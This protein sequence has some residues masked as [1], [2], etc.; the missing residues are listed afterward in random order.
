MAKTSVTS[1]THLARCKICLPAAWTGFPRVAAQ[2][3]TK[4][5]QQSL[6]EPPPQGVV[7]FRPAAGWRRQASAVSWKFRCQAFSVAVNQKDYIVLIGPWQT[8]L[9]A[10]P[11]R[12]S[13][14]GGAFAVFEC[15]SR[16]SN[17]SEGEA[18]LKIDAPVLRRLLFCSKPPRDPRGFIEARR[19]QTANRLTQVY[20]IEYIACVH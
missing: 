8:E 4:R 18:Q 17:V 2:P 14:K 1:A 7:C 20:M 12:P 19:K 13:A 15:L 6:A 11:M 5:C 10:T 3:Q 16:Y 9:P